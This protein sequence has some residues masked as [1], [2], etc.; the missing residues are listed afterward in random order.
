MV[1]KRAVTSQAVLPRAVWGIRRRCAKRCGHHG[2][3]LKRAVVSHK[4]GQCRRRTC[5]HLHPEGEAL[6]AKRTD[7]ADL[8]KVWDPCMRSG[9]L[10]CRVGGTIDRKEGKEGGTASR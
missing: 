1:L 10:V 6:A 9:V 4:P 2:T 3:K 8:K 7:L 5:A